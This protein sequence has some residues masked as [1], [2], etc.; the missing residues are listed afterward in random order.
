MSPPYRSVPQD[1]RWSPSETPKTHGVRHS[2][3][4]P[5]LAG[6]GGCG[7]P[8]TGLGR[9]L[10]RRSP[11]G[12][13]PRAAGPAKPRGPQPGLRRDSARHRLDAAARCS[14]PSPGGV[15]GGW[16]DPSP[17]QPGPGP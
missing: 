10:P 2:H 12:D 3:L 9:P 1:P 14:P 11:P 17:A 15:G 16:N 4:A 6:G 8:G 13:A 7:A 5:T